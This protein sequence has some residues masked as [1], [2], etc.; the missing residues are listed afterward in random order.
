MRQR[1]SECEDVACWLGNIKSKRSRS[2]SFSLTDWNAHAPGRQ[3]CLSLKPV[4][5]IVKT[6]W[7]RWVTWGILLYAVTGSGTFQ[8][9]LVLSV[10]STSRLFDS[11]FYPT[12]RANLTF[13]SLFPPLLVCNRSHS[14][15]HQ[16]YSHWP[17]FLNYNLLLS[18]HFTL[19]LFSFFLSHAKRVCFRITV[20]L[21][22]SALPLNRTII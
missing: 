17:R 16:Y 13:F 14:N 21:E 5:S 10:R 18:L 3:R 1:A 6:K 12:D 8:M 20:I 7:F 4:S 22:N 9:L 19:F 15:S 2:R 11:S